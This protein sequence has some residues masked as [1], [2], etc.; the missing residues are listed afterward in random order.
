MW[1]LGLTAAA[2]VL[3]NF[4]AGCGADRGTPSPG[5]AVTQYAAEVDK[6]KDHMLD[7]MKKKTVHGKSTQVRTSNR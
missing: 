7:R 2:M 4:V 3:V 1:K 6:L 5:T